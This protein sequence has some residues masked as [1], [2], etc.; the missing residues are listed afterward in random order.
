MKKVNPLASEG[1][2]FDKKTNQFGKMRGQL[3]SEGRG[4]R[5]KGEL[6]WFRRE[7]VR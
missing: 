1:K 5:E 4:F 3:P 6:G 2:W 7:M